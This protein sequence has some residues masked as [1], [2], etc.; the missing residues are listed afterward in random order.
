MNTS[1]HAL[2]DYLLRS[3]NILSLATV[4]PDG[5]PQATTVGYVHDGLTVYVGVADDSQKVQNI[6]HCDKVSLTIARDEPDWNRIRGLSMGA[7]AALVGDPAEIARVGEL[8]TAKFPQLQYLPKTEL[9]GVVLLR[10][11]PKVISLL[12]YT[13]GF[14]HT[15]LIEI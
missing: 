14:G 7:T 8:M 3:H 6:R 9:A 1:T 13:Q 15:E 10:I 2:I 11:T 5:Y 4:R 12:D